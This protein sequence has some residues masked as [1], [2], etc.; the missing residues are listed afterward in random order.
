MFMMIGRTQQRYPKR[1]TTLRDTRPDELPE[2]I[3]TP[4]PHGEHDSFSRRQSKR[5]RLA[6]DMKKLILPLSIW[7][8]CAVFASPALA[9]DSGAELLKPEEAFQLT[10]QLKETN[11]IVARWKIADGYYLYRSKIAFQSDTPGYR[12]DS[13][14]LPKGRIKHDEFFGDV[15]IYRNA[16]QAELPVSRAPDSGTT[17]QLTV[18]Y[19]GCADRGICYPPTPHTVSLSFPPMAPKSTASPSASPLNFLTQ[20]T[21]KPSGP[22]DD[23]LEPDQAFQF[24]VE[25]KNPHTLT[26]R[27]QVVAGYYLYR[28]KI[29]LDLDDHKTVAFGPISWAESKVKHDEFFGDTAIYDQDFEI[30]LPLTRK[31]QSETPVSL[32]AS[33]QGCA[34]AGICYPPIHK[35]VK[36]VLPPTEQS[37]SK[38]PSTPPSDSTHTLY[39]AKTPSAHLPAALSPGSSQKQ[40]ESYKS[41]QDRIAETLAT[42]TTWITL[43]SFFGFGLM[44]A[45]TPC[46]FPM[47][48]ILSG[49]IIGQGKGITTAKAFSLSLVYVLAVAFTYALAGVVVGLSGENIQAW[50]QNPWVLSA[51]AAIF[52]LLA[53]SMFGFYELQMP[54]A[55]QT[56]LA[57]ISNQQQGGTLVGVAI[58]GLLSALIVGPCVTAPLIGALIYIADSGDALLGGLA[59]FTLSLG[60]GTPLLIIGTSAGKILPK[61]GAWMDTA[62]AVFGVLLLGIAIW[63]LERILPIE[64]I[65]VASGA[66]LIVSAIYMGAVDSIM[67]GASGWL[68]FWKGVGLVMLL[69]GALLLVGAASGSKSMLQP[70]RGLMV[71]GTPI[72]HHALKFKRIKGVEGL[73]HALS[74]AHQQQK[75]L[76]LDLYA[77]WCV[78]CKEMEAYTFSDPKVQAALSASILVQS[79][80]TQNDPEDQGLLKALGLFGPPAILFHAPDG[81]ERRAYRVVGYMPAEQFSQHAAR[82]LAN[83]ARAE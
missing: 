15:E 9:V 22:V 68:R 72:P 6:C 56:R 50:F 65:M 45:F 55:L 73:E 64:A 83:D 67:S 58:M 38:N 26:A 66:L 27:W 2:T 8:L 43:I 13:A 53:L 4:I 57:T 41:E 1:E 42:G 19:Q 76:V 61:A 78:S 16:V 29:K 12:L 40:S 32:K 70:L 21:G 51:F 11:T 31:S 44:L 34:E 24:Q 54:N 62:K 33:Y 77:D 37:A 59:L 5:F 18:T 49:I 82:A 20:L 25:V 79:D 39:S 28:D 14:K 7:V 74:G 75:P 17:L 80:V 63:L 36:L 35:T 30:D 3:A 69:Y 47:I 71:A 46:V 60:M 52:V 81:Q 23:F 10:T 48:P